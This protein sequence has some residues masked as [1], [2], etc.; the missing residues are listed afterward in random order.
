[1]LIINSTNTLLDKSH[2]DR[3]FYKHPFVEVIKRQLINVL[4]LTTIR[5]YNFCFHIFGADITVIL[6]IQ[7]GRGT[8][9]RMREKK[10]IIKN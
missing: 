4:G 2:L 5:T 8:C 10:Q 7:I 3:V 1:M 6:A 9:L